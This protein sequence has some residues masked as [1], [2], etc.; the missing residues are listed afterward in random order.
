MWFQNEIMHIKMLAIL[1]DEL[2]KY[3]NLCFCLERMHRIIMYSDSSHSVLA[4]CETKH[5]KAKYWISI[6]SMKKMGKERKRKKKHNPFF[7]LWHRYFLKISAMVIFHI[8]ILPFR[9][10][11]HP[12]MIKS[13]KKNPPHLEWVLLSSVWKSSLITVRKIA[14]ADQIVFC[15]NRKIWFWK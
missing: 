6:K 14:I 15:Y 10:I 1:E 13:Y 4:I 2:W 8:V 9:R 12:E 11:E 3:S 5:A 7:L